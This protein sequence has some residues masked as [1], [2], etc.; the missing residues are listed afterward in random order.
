MPKFAQK[1]CLSWDLLNFFVTCIL[2]AAS[3]SVIGNCC[4]NSCNCSRCNCSV[5]NCFFWLSFLVV[6]VTFQLLYYLMLLYKI[7]SYLKTCHWDSIIKKKEVKYLRTNLSIF[8]PN[9]KRTVWNQIF[10]ILFKYKALNL[11]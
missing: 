6:V 5:S 8:Q 10:C 2:A 9:G 1:I 3:G 7:A 4:N 11:K